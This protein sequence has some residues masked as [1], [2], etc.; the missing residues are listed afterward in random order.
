MINFEAQI[1][2]DFN[3]S[4]IIN[5]KDADLEDTHGQKKNKLN[6]AVTY[7]YRI[8]IMLQCTEDSI[9][10]PVLLLIY[11]KTVIGKNKNHYHGG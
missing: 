5:I 7:Y 8:A 11:Y 4:E 3:V 2:T 9:E 10:K 6:T 1:Q